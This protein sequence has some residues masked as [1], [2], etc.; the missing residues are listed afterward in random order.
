MLSTFYQQKMYFQYF[1]FTIYSLLHPF[2]RLKISK[3]LSSI[4]V[5][6]LI[7]NVLRL[8]P[9]IDEMKRREEV[10]NNFLAQSYLVPTPQ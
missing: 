5:I 8:K 3:F 7:Q 10:A 6:S 2:L 9:N 4:S 1:F